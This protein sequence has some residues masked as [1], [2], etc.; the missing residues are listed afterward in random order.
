MVS[1][2]LRDIANTMPHMIGGRM[3]DDDFEALA[4]LPD[5]VLTIDLL[6][7]TSR[8]SGGKVLTLPV[9]AELATWLTTRLDAAKMKPTDVV[10]AELVIAIRTDRV[11]VDRARIIPFDLACSGTFATASRT[12]T[13]KPTASV[14]WYY[15][16]ERSMR[17]GPTI[18]EG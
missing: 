10:K 5:G 6:S 8:H 14:Q 13:S 11:P 7:G 18:A 2:I 1:K 16:N 9:V 15:R 12:Y 17:A 3:R 4:V